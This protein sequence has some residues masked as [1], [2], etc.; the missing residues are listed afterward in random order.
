[1]HGRLM[2]A[3]FSL[4]NVNL[5]L[6]VFQFHISVFL[7]SYHK[8]WS[9]GWNVDVLISCH[10]LFQDFAKSCYAVSLSAGITRGALVDATAVELDIFHTL[11]SS[12][13]MFVIYGG[14]QI[15]TTNWIIHF[16]NTGAFYPPVF[17][18]CDYHIPVLTNTNK[19]SAE[20]LLFIFQ[21]KMWLQ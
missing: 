12:S 2:L 6:F 16:K 7:L 4:A 13:A 18:S 17:P 15:I 9:S 10:I 8:V 21:H 1:M 20:N 3:H 5:W 19:V 14:L 11:Q